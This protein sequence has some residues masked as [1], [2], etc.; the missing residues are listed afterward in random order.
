MDKASSVVAAIN[1]GKLPTT[2]QFI[3][4]VDYLDEVG[5]TQVK[6]DKDS[7][8]L[9]AQ[10]RLLADDL[11]QVFYA[12]KQFFNN[13]NG[14]FF[15]FAY[16]FYSSDK[17]LVAADNTLQKAIYHLNKWDITSTEEASAE[18]D[19]ALKDLDTLRSSIR[20]LLRVWWSSYTSEGSLLY[21]DLLSLIRNSLADAA[22]IMEEKSGYTKEKLRKVES[23]VQEGKRD[24]L[25]R[26]K[27][28]LEQE[29]D[30]KVAWEHGMD[31]VKEAGVSV[32]GAAQVAEERARE[33]KEKTEGKLQ[34]VYY[35]VC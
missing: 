33:S 3:R 22:E 18:K 7:A 27:E 11:R 17:V 19:Q 6:S 8:P 16:Y 32:I 20:T 1:A 21:E 35:S 34:G 26:D 13:K 23:E 10:G 30:P 25:G 14:I 12:Y 24:S 9:T 28:R 29:K 5:I 15:L 31:T 4:F 2:Q